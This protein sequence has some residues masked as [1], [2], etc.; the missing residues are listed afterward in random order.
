MDNQSQAAIGRAL[1]LSPA[2]MTKCKRMG[3]PVHSV[4]AARTWRAINIAPTMHNYT[5]RNPTRQ[6][7]PSGA[8]PHALALLNVAA[9]ALASGQSIDALV[10]VLRLALRAVPEPERDPDM[11]LPAEVMDV[12]T[13]DV[14]AAIEHQDAPRAGRADY[15]NDD[16][17][18]SFV[19]GADMTDDEADEMGRFWYQVAAGEMRLA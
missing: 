18:V 3:M 4:E 14:F 7:S 1:G 8:L 10:P 13:H 5:K 17:K 2:S 9:A 6:P 19:T 12:L 11:M 15:S 16:G